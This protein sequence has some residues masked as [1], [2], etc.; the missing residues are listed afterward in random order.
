MIDIEKL[1]ILVDDYA[2]SSFGDDS[3]E[4]KR[5]LII[6]YLEKLNDPKLELLTYYDKNQNRTADK[7]KAKT[8]LFLIK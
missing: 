6:D 7:T 4:Q 1:M 8:A 5:K 2:I 3:A